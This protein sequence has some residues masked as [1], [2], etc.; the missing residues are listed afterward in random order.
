MSQDIQIV[1]FS[2]DALN[3]G[4]RLGFQVPTSYGGINIQSAAL[5]VEGTANVTLITMT[6]AGTPA[7]SGTIAAAVGGTATAG[8][9]YAF[10]ITDGGVD[11]G[12][13]VAAQENNIG[14]PTRAHVTVS[15]TMG[16]GSD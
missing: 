11:G 2:L 5:H 7:V 16:R 8:V 6:N 12:E 15:Y 13:W 14:T 10:T 3:N 9:P 1:T 4:N